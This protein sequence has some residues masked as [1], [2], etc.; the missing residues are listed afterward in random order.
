MAVIYDYILGALR[1][2]DSSALPPSG[3]TAGTY[4]YATVTFDATGIATFA[5]SGVSPSDTNIY[6]SDGTSTDNTRLIKTKTSDN[7]SWYS[8]QT[9]GA[10]DIMRIYGDKTVRYG[11]GSNCYFD[12]SFT[13]PILQFYNV[14]S[15][16]IR[17]YDY[18]TGL[19]NAKMGIGGGQGF[20]K[21]MYD[22]TNGLELNALTQSFIGMG[23]AGYGLTVGSTRI[24][25]E[26]FGVVGSSIFKGGGSTSATYNSIW[27]NS[28][29]VQALSIRD[30]GQI[31][32]GVSGVGVKKNHYGINSSS[33]DSYYGFSTGLEFMRVNYSN[34][35]LEFVDHSGNIN[36]NIQSYGAT[37]RG[38]IQI[39]GNDSSF[40][41]AN[42]SYLTSIVSQVGAGANGSTTFTNHLGVVKAAINCQGFIS[43][44]ADATGNYALEATGTSWFNGIVHNVKGAD[45][46]S[47]ADLTLTTNSHTITG[48]TTIN[49]MTILPFIAG[50]HITLVFSGATTVKHN[51]AGGAGTAVFKL[52]GSV[53]FVTAAD[54]VLGLYYDGTVFQ[55]TNEKHA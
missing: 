26:V 38:L 44:G 31:D 53:D 8:F 28:S 23:G 1:L 50:D 42:T 7:A 14:G 5:A 3:V 6:N 54:S 47:A 16:V 55:Q 12:T 2:S 52:A 18:Y 10:T 46:A 15:D 41:I 19:L 45:I 13:T 20:L 9:S 27:K 39:I 11:T 43:V 17:M 35:K 4:T 22:V 30:D 25:T 40:S 48:T 33:G 51:T 34:G 24:A 36:V 29:S 37:N 49:A 32:F 21:L